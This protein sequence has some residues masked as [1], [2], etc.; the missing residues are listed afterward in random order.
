VA[1][2]AVSDGTDGAQRRR[3][4]AGEAEFNPFVPSVADAKLT[5]HAWEKRGVLGGLPGQRDLE[6]S[7]GEPERS[8]AVQHRLD[9]G[10]DPPADGVASDLDS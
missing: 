8:P 4:L 7:S 2:E 5:V 9:L 3:V 10:V 6:C 1:N